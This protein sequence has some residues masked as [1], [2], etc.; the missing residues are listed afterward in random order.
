MRAHAPSFRAPGSVTTLGMLLL[1]TAAAAAPPP[2]PTLDHEV[3]L[4]EN[5]RP[6]AAIV[7]A[8]RAPAPVE[9]AVAELQYHLEKMTGTRLPRK[10]AT[11]PVTGPRILVGESAAT[12]RLG[13]DPTAFGRQEY[14]VQ[15]RPQTLI[16]IGRD[17]QVFGPLRYDDALSA[18][19]V[20]NPEFEL[21]PGWTR[22]DA[23]GTCYAV[24]HFLERVCGIRWYL[25]SK[26][27]MFVPQ[28]SRLAVRNLNVRRRPWMAYREATGY[29]KAVP[30]KLYWWQR[31]KLTP[32]DIHPFRETQLWVLR[33]K[34][35]G[36]AFSA[37]HSYSAWHS[38]FFEQHPDWFAQGRTKTRHGLE[39]CLTHPQVEEQM[40]RDA[41]DYFAGTDVPGIR[42]GGDYFAVVPLDSSEWC[43]CERCQAL[44]DPADENA[45]SVRVGVAG[46]ASRYVWRFIGRV[47][48]ATAET[49]PEK[50][51]SALAY[52]D[53]LTPPPDMKRR[54]NLAVMVCLQPSGAFKF[55]PTFRAWNETKLREWRQVAGELYVWLYTIYP[56]Y[57][58]NTKFPALIYPEFARQMRFFHEIGVKGFFDNMDG[59]L[60]VSSASGHF[61]K[62]IG[63]WPNPVEDFFSAYVLL[64]LAD[65]I[66]IDEHALYDEFYQLWYGRAGPAVKAFLEEAQ[67]IYNDTEFTVNGVPQESGYDPERDAAPGWADIVWGSVCSAADVESLGRHVARAHE[68]AD[69]PRAKAHVAL[70]DKAVYRCIVAGRGMWTPPA[71][72]HD[73]LR[74][75]APTAWRLRTVTCPRLPNPSAGV[76]SACEWDR[77][78]ALSG[79]VLHGVD[80]FAPHENLEPTAATEASILCD[81]THFYLRVV[82]RDPDPAAIMTDNERP[83]LGDAVEVLV[84]P[85][86]NGQ[87]RQIV[88]SPDGAVFNAAAAAPGWRSNASVST[89]RSDNGWT[90]LLA[91]PFESLGAKTP[92]PGASWR[93][94][95]CRDFRGDREFSAWN[96]TLGGWRESRY[97]GQI[98]FE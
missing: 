43:Q 31:T 25:P 27:G 40:I 38:R 95:L 65:D 41:R 26:A 70:F 46:L 80:P 55:N 77:A 37:N 4:V 67:L 12:R 33:N 10:T 32:D 48:D 18:D 35:W 96:P 14:L 87:W 64:K 82:C 90:V 63:V 49:S 3:R 42:A 22:W 19:D 85:D 5:G 51:I 54:E 98:L 23:V 7:T 79:F 17:R 86:A 20:V 94:N 30:K 71:P 2:E 92:A 53:W 39:L 88:V 47:A 93:F 66:R 78:A 83:W 69:T 36:D 52:C 24:Y 16:L 84:D 21:Y 58:R 1:L 59:G 11:D 74:T 56:Q 50:F 57:L 8:A 44:L 28:H 73:R 75:E 76:A 72:V 89:V 97:F 34:G 91:L 6:L 13:I 15:T 68:L 81:D 45:L 29:D 60:Y 62:Y 9:L 61:N